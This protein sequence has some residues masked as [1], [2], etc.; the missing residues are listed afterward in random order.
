MTALRGRYSM[1][2]CIAH[3]LQASTACEQTQS[4]RGDHHCRAIAKQAMGVQ[5][6]LLTL[7][8][9]LSL[10]YGLLL[11]LDVPSSANWLPKLLKQTMLGHLS[12]NLQ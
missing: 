2:S 7:T 10:P 11:P 5:A 3:R 9:D 1:R 6:W 4:G 8:T 12:C